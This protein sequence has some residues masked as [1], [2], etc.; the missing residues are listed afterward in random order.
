M[1]DLFEHDFD[2]AFDFQ[3]EH[4][5]DD[6]LDAFHFEHDGLDNGLGDGLDDMH[7]DFNNSMDVM[8]TN[9]GYEYDNEDG[10]VSVEEN[11]HDGHDY[12]QDGIRMGHTEKNIFDGEDIYDENHQF[13]GR[14]MDNGI[15]GE[16]V[17]SNHGFEGTFEH[18][19]DGHHTI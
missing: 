19:S 17:Y 18:G 15:G 7:H 12:I 9:H 13:V 11:I 2:A 1:T 6:G 16:F 14:T 5:F 4:D 3:N 10:H 8:H